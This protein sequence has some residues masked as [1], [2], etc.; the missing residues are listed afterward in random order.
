MQRFIFG[1]LAICAVIQSLSAEDDLLQI[2]TIGFE[3]VVVSDKEPEEKELNLIEVMARPGVPFSSKFKTGARTVTVSGELT[4]VDDG[5]CRVTFKYLRTIDTGK[6][7]PAP[8]GTEQP[9]LDQQSSAGVFVLM[10]DMPIVVG[11]LESKSE[12]KP[13]AAWLNN[14]AKVTKSKIN[15]ELLLTRSGAEQ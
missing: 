3:G 2:K 14:R 13:R 9:I 5:S 7:V 12:A 6:R 11:G 15:H 8:D 10:K 4:E 1:M